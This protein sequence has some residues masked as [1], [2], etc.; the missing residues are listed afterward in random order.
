MAA[1]F[2]NLWVKGGS[3]VKPGTLPSSSSNK[4]QQQHNS[5]S[6]WRGLGAHAMEPPL[7]TARRF[8]DEERL[9]DGILDRRLERAVGFNSKCDVLDAAKIVCLLEVGILEFARRLN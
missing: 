5:S 9:V 4:Q 7:V 2:N 1:S 8:A 3:L 6:K